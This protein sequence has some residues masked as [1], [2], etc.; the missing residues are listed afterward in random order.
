M[1]YEVQFVI[2]QSYHYKVHLPL[3]FLEYLDSFPK[4][5]IGELE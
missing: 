5:I 3:K 4:T 2:I 1:Y